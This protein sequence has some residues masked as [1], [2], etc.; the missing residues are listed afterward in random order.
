MQGHEKWDVRIQE[1]FV[2]HCV[3][4]V[5]KHSTLVECNCK[6][7]HNPYLHTMTFTVCFINVYLK[8]LHLQG[9]IG[10]YLSTEG[11]SILV[12]YKTR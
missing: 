12:R 9:T 10:F 5:A 6:H 4:L 11:T 1:L 8:S 3:Q 2:S 7:N